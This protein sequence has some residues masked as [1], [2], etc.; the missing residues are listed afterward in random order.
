MKKKAKQG[1]KKAHKAESSF[2]CFCKRL[3]VEEREGSSPSQ[4][5]ERKICAREA[6]RDEMGAGGSTRRDFPF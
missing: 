3:A 5:D 1:E 6:K 4:R 2:C